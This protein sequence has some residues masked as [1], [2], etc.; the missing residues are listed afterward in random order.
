MNRIYL[1]PNAFKAH[2]RETPAFYQIIQ[3]DTDAKNEVRYHKSQC[4]KDAWSLTGEDYLGC[5]HNVGIADRRCQ[6]PVWLLWLRILLFMSRR[7]P[8]LRVWD[9]GAIVGFCSWL[10]TGDGLA[11]TCWGCGAWSSKILLILLLLLSILII[12]DFLICVDF[13]HIFQRF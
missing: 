6:G 2:L 7:R 11:D 10:E 1:L 8:D 9:P 3:W 12:T 5:R 4:R 13:F